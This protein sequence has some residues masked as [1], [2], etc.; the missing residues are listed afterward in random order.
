MTELPLPDDIRRRLE[1]GEL[2]VPDEL[3]F[4]DEQPEQGQEALPL[5][6]E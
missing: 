4:D 5:D 2:A 3:P 1:S 6:D